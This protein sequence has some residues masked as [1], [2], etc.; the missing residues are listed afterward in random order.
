MKISLHGDVPWREGGAR[1]RGSIRKKSAS[2]PA[3]HFSSS[4]GSILIISISRPE[5]ASRFEKQHSA[6]RAYINARL[7]RKCNIYLYNER[8]S[9]V[10]RRGREDI[11]SSRRFVKKEYRDVIFN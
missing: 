8:A 6:V 11:K 2:V 10:S 3:L 5:K 1:A 9:Y 7:R 4:T